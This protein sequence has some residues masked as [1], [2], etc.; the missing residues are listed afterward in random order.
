M[1]GDLIHGGAL[2]VMRAM[3]PHAPE[4]WM[5]LSTGINPW[6][7][8]Y[9]DPALEKL[10]HLPL[11][12]E[13]TACRD[14]M[15][16]SIGAPSQ[17]VLLA[18]GSELLIRLLPDLLHLKRVAILSPTYGDHATAWTR[19]GA[20][21]L[22]HPNPLSLA[23]SVEAVIVTQP[24]NPDGRVFDRTELERARETLAKRKG[25]LIV[26][27]AYADLAPELSLAPRAGT[28]GLIVLRSFGKFFGLAGLRLGA[29]L[30]PADI[31]AAMADRLGAWPISGLALD[32]G[33]HAYADFDWQTRMRQQLR[34][35]SFRLKETLV[36]GGLS[37][38]GGT[39]LFQYISTSNADRVFEHL[40]ERGIYVRRFEGSK[41]HLRVGLPASP[42]GERRLAEALSLLT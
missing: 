20:E 24:N 13:F 8:P 33:A 15:A 7:Y 25:W 26:D 30:A 10:A 36:R 23:G 42:E 35:A 37:V 39:G 27:E 3:F 6:P 38:I 21:I 5:D 32:I 41:T 4:P 1:S 14:A 16:A 9:V 12:A 19:V 11:Q 2:D 31:Q 34:G 22:H 28:P 18:P 40:A 17:S 29:L